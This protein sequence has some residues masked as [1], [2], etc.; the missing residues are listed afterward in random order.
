MAHILHWL[1]E[2]KHFVIAMLWLLAMCAGSAQ[3][4]HTRAVKF[5]YG[6]NT[7]YDCRETWDVSSGRI[8]TLVIFVVTFA[9]PVIILIFV[10]TT[11]AYHILR[12]VIPGNPD[13]LRDE[14]QVNRK[15]K[16]RAL[17]YFNFIIILTILRNKR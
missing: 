15:I 10:Y 6:Q 5:E 9:A 11:I 2:H 8:Y 3:L 13:C 14:N 4:F 12:H 17:S 16:A 1:R 7:Y